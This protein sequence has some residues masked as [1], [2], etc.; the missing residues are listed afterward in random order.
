MKDVWLA[1]R[2]DAAVACRSLARV[3]TYTTTIILT[4]ALVFGGVC[5]VFCVL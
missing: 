5:V 1:I 4:L 3:P 2:E